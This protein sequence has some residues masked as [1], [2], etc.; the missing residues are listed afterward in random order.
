MQRMLSRCQRRRTLEAR[1]PLDSWYTDCFVDLLFYG[2]LHFST[3]C[4]K[5][6][7]QPLFYYHR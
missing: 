6:V 5:F 3:L 7:N 2:P 4:K 1:N